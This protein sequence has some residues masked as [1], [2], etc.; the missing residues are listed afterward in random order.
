MGTFFCKRFICFSK[1]SDSYI[2]DNGMRNAYLQQA[3]MNS[4]KP[5]L[6]E[7][8]VANVVERLL[9]GKMKQDN[10][11]GPQL[12]LWFGKYLPFYFASC[13][14]ASSHHILQ[15]PSNWHMPFSPTYP[16]VP[17]VKTITNLIKSNYYYYVVL[18]NIALFCLPKSMHIEEIFNASIA[19][20]NVLIKQKVRHYP[21]TVCLCILQYSPYYHC[22]YG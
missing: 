13:S 17:V 5:A 6:K 8:R 22:H 1:V 2:H 10:L 19:S 16:H 14:M 18:Q 15:Y 4:Q 9:V 12:L 3:T 11:P 20:D 21:V 7:S